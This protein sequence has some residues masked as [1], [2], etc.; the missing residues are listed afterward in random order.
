MSPFLPALKPFGPIPLEGAC[1]QI[2]N[3]DT[4]LDKLNQ[5]EFKVVTEHMRN[6]GGAQGGGRGGELRQGR[7]VSWKDRNSGRWVCAARVP[8][9]G[10]CVNNVR[11]MTRFEDFVFTVPFAH[12]RFT[13]LY[14]P[15]CLLP[16]PVFLSAW[17]AWKDCSRRFGRSRTF[18]EGCSRD[19]CGDSA[20]HIPVQA[21][22]ELASWLEEVFL[23]E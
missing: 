6:P 12:D 8:A 20:D 2:R 5:E 11:P 1:L 7:V 3:E 14:K 16:A 23:A 10:V 22:D 18:P 17:T 9:A 4:P 15:G 21:D 19:L 13:K